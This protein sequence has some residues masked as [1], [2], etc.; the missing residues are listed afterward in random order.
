MLK[1]LLFI[2]FVLSLTQ[3]HAQNEDCWTL[4]NNGV[5][6]YNGQYNN[7]EFPGY[8][9]PETTDLEEVNG[10]FLTT[11]QYNKQTFDSNDNNIYTNLEDKDGGYLTKHDYNGN[12]K[13]IVY[14]EKNVNSYRDVMFGSVEDNEGNIYVIGHSI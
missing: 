8:H 6:I 14:T 3:L 1:K 9:D 2:L 7:N 4:I 12:L 10:G 11:G 5:D 13:W